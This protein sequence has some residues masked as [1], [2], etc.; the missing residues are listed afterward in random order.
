M[1]KGGSSTGAWMNAVAG[2]AAQQTGSNGAGGLIMLNKDANLTVGGGKRRKKGGSMF[3]DLAVPAV[4]LYANNTVRKSMKHR[5][6]K[7]VTRR[8]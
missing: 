3:A 8:R 4:L 2:S 5:S 1:K 7:R 6:N